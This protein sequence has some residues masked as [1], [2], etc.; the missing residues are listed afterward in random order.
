MGTKK[1]LALTKILFFLSIALS[2]GS[3]VTIK[4]GYG[5]IYPFFYWKLFSQPTGWNGIVEDYRVYAKKDSSNKWVRLENHG[6]KDFDQD[7]YFYFILK[8]ANLYEE[9]S[10]LARK[11]TLIF[12]KYI[13]PE[14]SS[15]KI[16]KETF[17]PYHTVL[18]KDSCIKE[19]I[20]FLP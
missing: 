1:R 2:I 18:K 17:N 15:Y 19:D 9:D 3:F 7:D 20:I 6:Y 4:K 14:Y 13:A 11:K 5:E 12:C 10:I 16:V 8:Q